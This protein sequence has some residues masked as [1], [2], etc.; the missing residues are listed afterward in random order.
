MNKQNK[1]PDMLA[2]A[3]II[4]A[5]TRRDAIMQRLAKGADTTSE[6]V[7]PTPTTENNDP[8]ST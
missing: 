3:A 1:N 4:L 5:V 2:A 7:T 6:K 8:V